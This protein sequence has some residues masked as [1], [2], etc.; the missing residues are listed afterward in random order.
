MK[1][2]ISQTIKVSFSSPLSFWF[3]FFGAVGIGQ[4]LAATRETLEAASR[5]RDKCR[6]KVRSVVGTSRDQALE[7][8]DAVYGDRRELSSGNDSS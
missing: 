4:Q 7:T 1:E 2:M 3:S 6:R 8:S 5:T